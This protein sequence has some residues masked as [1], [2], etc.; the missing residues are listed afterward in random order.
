MRSEAKLRDVGL[1]AQ[2]NG[3]LNVSHQRMLPPAVAAQRPEAL[4]LGGCFLWCVGD[5]V[6]LE[7]VNGT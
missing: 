2:P 3:F 1:S 4:E 6:G 7:E 5:T